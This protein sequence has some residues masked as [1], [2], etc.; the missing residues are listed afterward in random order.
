MQIKWEKAGLHADF[1]FLGL[2][3]N[4]NLPFDIFAENS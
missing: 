2:K 4:S 1:Q 3:N